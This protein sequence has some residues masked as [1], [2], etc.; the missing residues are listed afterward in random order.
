MAKKVGGLKIN[1]SMKDETGKAEE[2]IKKAQIATLNA[3]GVTAVNHAKNGCPVKTGRLRSSITYA[4]GYEGGDETKARAV[5]IGTNVKYARYVEFNEK[6]RHIVGGPHF[7]RNAALNH[8][9]EYRKLAENIM[10]NA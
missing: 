5:Y 3:I 2:A 8:T 6:V 7:L 9:D 4:T 10:K 1:I